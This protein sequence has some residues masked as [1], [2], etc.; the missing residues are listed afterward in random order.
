M[1]KI[2]LNVG[3]IIISSIII[4]SCN[5]KQSNSKGSCS[6]S[7]AFSF[8]KK[9]VENA[10][11]QISASKTI[12]SSNENCVYEFYFEGLNRYNWCSECRITVKYFDNDYKIV[13]CNFTR[14]Q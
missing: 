5:Q 12:S 14:C 2:I 8:A 1:K 3:M 13:A 7:A 6:E 9:C 11:L 4:I 10:P